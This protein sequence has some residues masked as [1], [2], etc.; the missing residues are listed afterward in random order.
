MADPQRLMKQGLL[1]ERKRELG[2]LEDRAEGIIESIQIA[3]FV[4]ASVFDLDADRVAN[5]ARELQQ[6]IK[7]GNELKG[8]IDKLEDQ[9][10]IRD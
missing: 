8:E 10:G 3:V 1:A 7:K 4:Q 5:Y 2:A 9:L 6:V